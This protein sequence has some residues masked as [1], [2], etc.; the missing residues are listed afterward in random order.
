MNS[1]VSFFKNLRKIPSL[2]PWGMLAASLGGF[3]DATYLAAQ[4]YLG[5]T[6][7]CSIFSGCEEVLTSSYAAV[8]G[9]PLALLGALYYLAVFLTIILYLD[10]KDRRYLKFAALFTIVGFLVSLALLYLQLFVI[11]FL[12][13]YCLISAGTSAIL[14]VLGIVVLRKYRIFAKVPPVNP[15]A[16]QPS[17]RR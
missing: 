6:P 2:I 3:L 4:H 14:F 7:N 13:F 16:Q 10:S 11:G 9:V 8:A 1:A 15:P 17:E 5:T 12:C